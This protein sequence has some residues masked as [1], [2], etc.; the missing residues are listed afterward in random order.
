M[1]T[2]GLVILSGA[3]LSDAA[4]TCTGSSAKLAQAE[5]DAWGDFYD[6]AGGT[7]WT[8]CSAARTD[9]CSCKGTTDK[10]PVCTPDGTSVATMYVIPAPRLFASRTFLLRLRSMLD[11]H[12]PGFSAAACTCRLSSN[13][14]TP[15]AS[16]AC[17][18]ATLRATT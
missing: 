5:C 6:D 2:G 12:A 3:A 10:N 17:R 11:G 18:A 9:P 8:T 13:P 15:L 1:R 14:A 7:G 16:T 4:T